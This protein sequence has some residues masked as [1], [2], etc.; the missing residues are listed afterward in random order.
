MI[1]LLKSEFK[2]MYNSK[3]LLIGFGIIVLICIGVSIIVFNNVSFG[4]N[5]DFYIDF[6][7]YN[8]S[9]VVIKFF[10]PAIMVF[11]TASV[12]GG[13]YANGMIKTFMLCRCSKSRFYFC[14]IVFLA[15]CG[16][17]VVIIAF[18]SLSV[19]CIFYN[20]VDGI[21][22]KDIIVVAKVYVLI[23]I[24]QLP[25]MLL[26]MIAS[27]FLNDFHRS[28]S[29]G[30]ILLLLSLSAD[31]VASK[32][33]LLPTYFLSHSNL[34]YYSQE[35]TESFIVLALYIVVICLA[36]MIIFKNKDIWI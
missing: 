13:E 15:I 1:K 23:V 8:T 20:D 28:F 4:E 21:A 5:N 6:M 34:V 36:G 25:I 33:F 12:W 14:K 2:K 32:S 10:I 35:K 7:L 9:F 22:M 24:G 16:I 19:L 3:L 17:F 30:L 11:L 26:T 29:C 18:A 31:S 27:M